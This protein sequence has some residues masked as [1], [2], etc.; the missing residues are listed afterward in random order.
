MQFDN[1]EVDQMLRRMTIIADTRE[2]DTPALRR[3][4]QD[5]G[6]TVERRALSYG[7]YTAETTLPD[8]TTYSLAD[9]LV[10]ERKMNLDELCACF[11]KGRARFK[12]EFDRA[13]A[14]GAKVILLVESGSWEKAYAGKYRSLYTPAALV[15]SMFA[16]M[17]RY[18]MA[19]QFCPAELS[20]RL[21]AGILRYAL[22][23]R[24]ETGLPDGE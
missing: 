1:F 24:L 11:G 12:R 6:C 8:G 20:G 23:E 19:P 21:I 2:Q 17:E 10:I 22:K 16:W 9:K 7:D 18:G 5:M 13:K 14:D 15:A 3:R 4:I